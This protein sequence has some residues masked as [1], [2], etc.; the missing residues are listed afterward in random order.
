MPRGVEVYETGEGEDLPFPDGSF[1]LVTSR[2]PVRPDWEEVHRVLVPGGRYVAQHVG[3][4]SA[5]E[6]M[7]SSSAPCPSTA[8]AETHGTRRT[9]PRRPGSRSRT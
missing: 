9:Q 4:A 8:E 5:F 2:H 3:P 1:D 7:S 6:L